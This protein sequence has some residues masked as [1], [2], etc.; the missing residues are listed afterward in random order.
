M[1]K[2]QKI[3][4]SCYE[5]REVLTEAGRQPGSYAM[6]GEY[7]RFLDNREE[8]RI[9]VR[10]GAGCPQ[11]K[12]RDQRPICLEDVSFSY[13]N[14]EKQAVENVTLTIPRAGDEGGLED[15]LDRYQFRDFLAS[16]GGRSFDTVSDYTL[17]DPKVRIL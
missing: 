2:Y 12:F 9:P 17:R 11:G 8:K 10:D 13:P 15:F 5:Q 7:F 3:P 14:A 4:Y 1:E 16:I 6:A